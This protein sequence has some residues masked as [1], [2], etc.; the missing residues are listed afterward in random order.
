MYNYGLTHYSILYGIPY[1][2][3]Y[4]SL[5]DR[6]RKGKLGQAK[7]DRKRGSLRTVNGTHPV[8]FT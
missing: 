6:D 5:N 3:E 8:G 7:I 2:S 4:L 1:C